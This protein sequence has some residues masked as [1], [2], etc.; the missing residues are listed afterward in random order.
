MIAFATTFKFARKEL[1]EGYL[2]PVA[3]WSRVTAQ[4][5]GVVSRRLVKAGDRVDTGDVLFELAPGD[6]VD[7]GVSVETRLLEELNDKRATLEAQ[8]SVIQS[9]FEN[10]RALIKSETETAKRQIG[11]LES[12]MGAHSARLAIARQRYQDGQRLKESGALSESDAL[13]LADQ[14]QSLASLVVA[15]Q[16]NIARLR[17]VLDTHDERILR[18]ELNRK[19]DE[20]RIQEQLYTLAMEESRLRVRNSAN[21]LA[22]RAGRVASVRG[23][24]GDWLRPGDPLLDI[25]P[26]DSGLK[27]RLYAASAAMGAIKVGQEVRVYLDA[28]PYQKHG[29]QIGQ[30]SSISE[31]TLDQEEAPNAAIALSSGGPLF[32]IDVEF[33]D[34][35]NLSPEQSRSLRPGMTISADLVIDYGTLVDWLLEPLQGAALRI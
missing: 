9:Q 28:F 3:G 34:G 13:E 17:T 10:E 35:F 20:A 11:L 18:L 25:V 6:G 21:I 27:A 24:P 2:T 19:R 30:V 5:F 31:T 32:R 29:A 8:T 33:P 4:S 22:P 14:V 23:N 26:E 15:P 1:A 7:A 12:E 16:R